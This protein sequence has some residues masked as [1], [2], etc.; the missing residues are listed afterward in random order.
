[1]TAIKI[2]CPKATIK[3]DDYMDDAHISSLDRSPFATKVTA[4]WDFWNRHVSEMSGLTNTQAADFTIKNLKGPYALIR[5]DVVLNFMHYR[6][7]QYRGSSINA[8]PYRSKSSFVSLHGVSKSA[9]A[10]ESVD[11]FLDGDFPTAKISSDPAQYRSAYAAC[12]NQ[13][14]SSSACCKACEKASVKATNSRRRQ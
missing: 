10:I 6:A 9:A 4:C 14:H 2:T 12:Y 1:M 11:V 8:L 3:K 7:A 5:I 13:G